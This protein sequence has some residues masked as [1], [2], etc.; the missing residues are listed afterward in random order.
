MSGEFKLIQVFL[1]ASSSN[2]GP[3][4]FEVSGD[5]E[6]NLRCTCPGFSIKGICKHTRYVFERIKLNNGVYPI[7]IS[8]KA[9]EVEA[10]LAKEDP[11][12]FRDFLLKYGKIEVF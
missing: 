10:S 6:Q 8:T 7:E 11:E 1:S 2:P 4:I 9:S 3:G 5:E 12:S